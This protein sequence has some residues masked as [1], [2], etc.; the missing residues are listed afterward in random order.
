MNTRHETWL[1]IAKNHILNEEVWDLGAGHLC[2]K[3][4]LLL[5]AGAAKVIA[6]DKERMDVKSPRITRIT[7]LFCDLPPPTGRA[8][9]FLSFPQNNA[10]PGLNDLLKHFEKVIYHGC[11]L[12]STSC[13][14]PSLFKDCLIKREILESHTIQ[15][16]STIIYGP[17]PRTSDEIHPEEW[18]AI[19]MYGPILSFQQ[20]V[21][22][23]KH[24]C[25]A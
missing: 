1:P 6:V 9:A 12:K 11:N 14:S 21:E 13:G 16:I 4:T 19:H 10:L 15:D 24:R 20:A 22:A 5:V 2:H 8:V 17:N 23:L 7:S 18:A 3:S 25:R